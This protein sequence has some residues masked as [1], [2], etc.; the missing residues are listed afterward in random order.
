M[1]N[2]FNYVLKSDEQLISIDQVIEILE[3][4]SKI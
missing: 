3:K 4:K 1:I 2:Y